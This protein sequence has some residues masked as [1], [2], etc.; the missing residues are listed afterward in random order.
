MKT[1]AILLV[2]CFLGSLLVGCSGCNPGATFTLRNPLLIDKE[3]AS[4]AGPRLMAVPQYYAPQYAPTAPVQMP[5]GYG[6]P[7]IP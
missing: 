5:A 3:P 7:C 1:I 4:R 2:C 6:A